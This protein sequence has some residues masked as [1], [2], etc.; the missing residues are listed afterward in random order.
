MPN[1]LLSADSPLYSHPLPQ[2]EQWLTAL[3]CQQDK[4]HLHCWWV[5]HG[6]WQAQIALETEEIVVCYHPHGDLSQSITRAFKYSLS[7]H[8]VEAAIL[9]GP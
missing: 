1:S 8:D 3:G 6:D 4:E 7:R 2:I 5:D 9:D